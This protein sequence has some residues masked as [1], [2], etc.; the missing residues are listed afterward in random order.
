MIHGQPSMDLWSVDIRRFGK[1]ASNRRFLTDRITE[2]LGLHYQMAW[3]NRE[4][5]TGRDA[6]NPDS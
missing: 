6:Q 5:L 2:V 3:P 4:F 1:W